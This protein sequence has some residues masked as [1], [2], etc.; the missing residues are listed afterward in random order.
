MRVLL[1]STYELGHQPLALATAA[2]A[3]RARGHT[4]DCLDVSR[5]PPRGATIA[6]ADLVA[7]AVPMHTAT[8]LAIT[9]ARQI[10]ALNPRAHR[11][12]FGLYAAPLE[13]ALRRDGL[14]DSVIGGEYE[15]GLA[16]L[17]EALA[18]GADPDGVPGVGARPRFDRNAMP[19]PDRAG[20]P[21]LERYAHV[22]LEPEDLRPAG[23]VEAS[24]GCAHHCRHCPIPPVYNGRLRL[25]PAERVLADIDHLAGMGARHI[26]FGDPDFFNAVPH[27]LA[28]TEALHRR[29]PRVTFDATIKVEHLLAHAEHLPTLRARGGVFLTSA[30]ESLNNNIL[31]ILEKGH[32]RADISR[33]VDLVEDAGLTLRG[34]WVP[35]TPWTRLPDLLEILEFI[36]RRD[37]IA[38]TPP[39]QLALRLLLPPGSALLDPVRDG[40][41]LREYDAE[42]LTYRWEHP[43]PRM[44]ALQTR[45]AALVSA[46]GGAQ[47]PVH[48]FQAI[49]AATR[50]TLGL[51][52]AEPV[53]PRRLHAPGR[54]EAWFCCAEPTEEQL[55]PLD[56]AISV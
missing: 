52:V 16:D 49:R 35:F 17:A 40:G 28:I 45:L 8:R 41:F 7:F 24:R 37:L 29:H 44:E 51:P 32:T 55:A 42:G 10:R 50:D 6:A 48:A 3:L 12:F 11:C 31:A 27:A 21:P 9:L 38:A 18:R 13:A 14:A 53:R 23:Y 36:E 39:V 5:D 47:D 25:V 46:P 43:D 15:P 34:T 33:A 1:I 19:L 22:A 30:F 54:T 2:A 56:A 26:T 4:V 20:L